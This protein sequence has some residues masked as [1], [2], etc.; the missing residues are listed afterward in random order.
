MIDIAVQAA[1]F[2]FLCFAVFRITVARTGGIQRCM[3]VFALCLGFSLLLNAPNTRPAP[4]L[5]ALLVV[6]TH[7][8]KLAALTCVALMAAMLDRPP[9]DRAARAR[10]LGTGLVVQLASALLYAASHV[11]VTEDSVLVR[12]GRSWAFALYG[13]LFAAYGCLCVV[14]LIRV[15]AR[16]AR[17]AVP[18]PIRTGLRL[19]TLACCAGVLWTSWAL[20][21]A[22]EVLRIGRVGLGEDLMSTLLGVPVALLGVGGASATFWPGVLAAPARWFRAR[23]TFHALEPLWAALYAELPGIALDGPPARRRGGLPWRATFE[24]YRRVVEI[25]D[26]YLALRPYAEPETAE[27]ITSSARR[28]D[29]A[30]ARREAALEADAIAAALENR[31]LGRRPGAPAPEA[32]H[33]APHAPRTLADEADWLRRVA[34]AFARPSEAGRTGRRVEAADDR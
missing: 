15:L 7:G 26:A 11:T 8:L 3:W 31:R 20:A 16:H 14:P 25:R 22:L 21:D 13:A 17:R 1:G 33:P 28:P 6:L 32:A 2:I 23:R 24:L 30:D 19:M 12:P 5:A 27:W 29:A 9:A 4:S 18:G 10:R 34:H